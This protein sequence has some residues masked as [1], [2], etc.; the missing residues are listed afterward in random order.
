MR[1]ALLCCA[2]LI[3]G[4]AIAQPAGQQGTGPGGHGPGFGQP[5]Y[6]QGSPDFKL[7]P[8]PRAALEIPPH[9]RDFLRFE[10][11]GHLEQLS[12]LMA[13]VAE[14]NFK[15]AAA[16]ARTG[17]AVMGNHPP[18]APAPGAFMPQ[19]FR[20]MGQAMHMAAAEVA[21]VGDAAANPPGAQDWKAM[22]ESVGNLTAACAGCHG[23]FRLK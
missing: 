8:D 14:G 15:E 6:G 18:G 5:G 3:A 4:A 13:R 11:R 22:M 10:M 7:P 23:S 9:V 21:R 1:I 16:F 12:T 20:A 2:A 17:L 19:E